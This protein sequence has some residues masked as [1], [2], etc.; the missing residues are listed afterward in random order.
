MKTA[1]PGLATTV[2]NSIKLS[3]SQKKYTKINRFV[4]QV[5]DNFLISEKHS[6]SMGIVDEEE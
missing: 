1:L 2:K 3:H 4:R 6:V 5:V